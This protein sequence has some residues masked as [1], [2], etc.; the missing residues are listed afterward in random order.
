MGIDKYVQSC[1]S[2]M[3][4]EK[5][6]RLRGVKQEWML[7]TLMNENRLINDDEDDVGS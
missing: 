3:T 1:H 6:L 4:G 7:E 5:G 2:M